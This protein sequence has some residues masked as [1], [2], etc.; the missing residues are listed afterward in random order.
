MK[1]RLIAIT[2]PLKGTTISLEVAETIIG[3]DPGSANAVTV[4]DPLVSRKHCSI[5]NKGGQIQLLDLESLNGTF[6]NSG[7]TREK[8][9]EHGDRIKVGTSQ[10]IFLIKDD[11]EFLD[12][13]LTD[14]FDEQY[15]TAVT[16][17]LDQEKSVYL[18]PE[19]IAESLPPGGRLARDLATLLKIST[20][21]CGIRKAEDLQ[22]RVLEMIFEVMPVERAAI[23]LVGQNPDE[24]I[25]GTHREKGSDTSH[26]FRI[27]RTIARQVLREGVAVMG[28]DVLTDRT[29]EPSE[30]MVLSQIRSL[31]CVPLTVF[32]T[33]LGV[34]YADTTHPGAHLDEDHLHFLTAIASVVAVAL[35]HARYVEWLE[36]ENR[37][38]QEEINIEHDMIGESG[39]MRD[40]YQFIGR[41]AAFDSTVLIRGESG[42]GKELVARAIHRNSK[43]AGRP[44]VAINCAALTESLLESELF[45]HEKGAFTGAI[46]QKKG[47][48]E[49]ADSGTLFLDEIG[50]LA[51]T[52]Q[53]KLL[54]VLQE[55][56]FDRVG[57][58]RPIKVDIRLIAATN[59]NIEEAIKT[60]GF[61]QDLF[62][63]LNV[64]SVN[65]PSL[66]DRREDIPLLAT[67]F[68]QK[69]S[70][71]A[72]RPVAGISPEAHAL[73]KQ[74][75][76]PGNVR[77]LENAVERA[78]VLGSSD[79]IRPEDLPEA[80]VERKEPSSSNILRYHDTVNSVKRQLIIKAV[81]QAGGNFTEA[82]K[83]LNLH[84]N[85]LHRLIRNMDIR[86]DLR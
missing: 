44:F 86:K 3:R 81:Q 57:G 7:P 14:S 12:E 33:K 19:K 26:P 32:G 40:I 29:F 75:D 20:A 46:A 53:A 16:V 6:V 51:P 11:D 22:A 13:Q 23:L 62:Y 35:E 73:L 70:R 78:V 42:T 36:G 74:Y 60:A 18:Q 25:S 4:N 72:T 65:L 15:T 58:T 9:L 61:R 5:L 50:E 82:A 66:R 80:L 79:H 76:W 49:V 17:K 52:L 8:M 28:N 41:V 69:Y 83:L 10:F 68:I 67:Y 43:R 27:S 38:L 85:Y 48:I 59:R 37:R 45:G 54:R 30:S 31:L 34:I 1:P 2:G 24:F 47:K 21:V 77:E 55:R 84:P 64:V 39:R 63:R 71:E 56:E